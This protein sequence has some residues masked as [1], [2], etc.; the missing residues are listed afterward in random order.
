MLRSVEAWAAA[1][2]TVMLELDL[3]PIGDEG[4][5]AWLR[6]RCSKGYGQQGRPGFEQAAMDRTFYITDELAGRFVIS[7]CEN[8]QRT[9]APKPSE[10]SKPV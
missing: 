1:V 8:I 9:N 2:T 3:D 7:T 4:G 10:D 5:G 6:G